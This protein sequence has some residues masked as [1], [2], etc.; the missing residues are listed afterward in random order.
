M[1][2]RSF[3]VFNSATVFSVALDFL[4]FG[5]QHS[6]SRTA[7]LFVADLMLL[8]ILATF[9]SCF[10]SFDSLVFSSSLVVVPCFFSCAVSTFLFVGSLCMI[11][12]LFV[13]VLSLK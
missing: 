2:V 9:I 3:R 4:C 8:A 13:G 12:Y 10:S 5:T 11:V 1:A 6:S 7:F